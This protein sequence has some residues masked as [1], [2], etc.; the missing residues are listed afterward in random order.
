MSERHESAARREMGADE[1][2]RRMRPFPVFSLLVG[3]LALILSIGFAVAQALAREGAGLVICGRDAER[4]EAAT[5]ELESRGATVA[6]FSCDVGDQAQVARLVAETERLFGRLDIF[7]AAAGICPEAMVEELDQAHVDAVF[8][9]NVRG[10]LLTTQAAA[11]TLY[12]RHGDE[13]ACH[14][15]R[16][17]AGLLRPFAGRVHR[18]GDAALLTEAH[19]LDPEAPL[20]RALGFWAGI[21]G[22]APALDALELAHLADVPVR[23]LSTGQRRRAGLARVVAGGAALWLLDEPANGLDADGVLLLERLL[24]D[25]RARGGAAMVAS[26]TPVALP[27]AVEV[28]L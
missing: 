17:A 6:G 22:V 28:R 16:V 8:A 24:A 10:L 21:D 3:I 12:A 27:H 26:H 25:H 4:A 11:A 9:V 20:G 5:A 15:L 14:L 23:L 18:G 1:D 7:V 2:E 19:A 13:A